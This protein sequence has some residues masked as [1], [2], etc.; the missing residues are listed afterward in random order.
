MKTDLPPGVIEAPLTEKDYE[1]AAV[2]PSMEGVVGFKFTR[3]KDGKVA[4]AVRCDESTVYVAGWWT[5]RSGVDY[6]GG[7]TKAQ[8]RKRAFALLEHD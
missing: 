7:R 1:D 3:V 6:D 5:A 2:M 8:A 4:Y